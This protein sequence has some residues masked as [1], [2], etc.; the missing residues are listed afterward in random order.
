MLLVGL[1]AVV[2]N[3]KKIVSAQVG[4]PLGLLSSS[5]TQK[6]RRM[7]MGIP[8]TISKVSLYDVMVV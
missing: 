4:I 3:A 2:E 6:A 8:L 1:N 5:F 7:I